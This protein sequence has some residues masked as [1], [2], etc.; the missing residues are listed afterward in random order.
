M[1]RSNTRTIVQRQLAARKKLWPEISEEMLWNWKE[2]KGF[3]PVP[4]LLPLMMSIM[5]DLSGK[6]FPVG[7]TYF[8]RWSRLK[9]DFC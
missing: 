2:R 5:D 3:I 4:R 7:Q 9:F 8:E 6:G 1:A